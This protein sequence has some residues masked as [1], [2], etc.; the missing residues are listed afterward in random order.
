MVSARGTVKRPF[1]LPFIGFV[2]K[3]YSTHPGSFFGEMPEVYRGNTLKRR[4][5]MGL[6]N[7]QSMA[8]TTGEIMRSFDGPKTTEAVAKK[9]H[10]DQMR[11]LNR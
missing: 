6:E 10:K 2:Q 4:S 11:F 3:I 7:G 1:L 5:Q 9:E 8:R